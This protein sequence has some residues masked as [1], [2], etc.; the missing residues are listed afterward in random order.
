M[1]LPHTNRRD[2]PE[3]WRS[4]WAGE[5]FVWPSPHVRG[6]FFSWSPVAMRRGLHLSILRWYDWFMTVGCVSANA[7]ERHSHQGKLTL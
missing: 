1:V 3:V 5:Y 4:C 7:L 2:N 6:F